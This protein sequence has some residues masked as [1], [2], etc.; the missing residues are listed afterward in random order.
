M[1]K[2]FLLSLQGILAFTL[3]AQIPSGYYATLQGKQTAE[4]KT[5]LHDIIIKDTTRYL[6]YGSGS[7]NRT[8]YGFYNT[9]RDTENS[10][11]LDMYSGV[12]RYFPSNY[13]SSGYPGFGNELHIE[14]SLPKSWWGGY[15][16]AAYKDLNHLY[17][18]DGSTNIS[19][20]DNPLGIVTGN[21]TTNN[22]VSK[23]GPG[24]YPGFAGTV[25]EPAN[26]YKGD[27][28]RSYFYMA[29]A[30]EHYVNVWAVSKPENMMQK[31]KYPVLN[32]GAIELLLDWHR[33]DPVSEKERTRV[34]KVFEIQGN[35]NPFIDYPELVE[36]IWGTLKDKPWG[37]IAGAGDLKLQFSITLS[38]L[39][40]ILNIDTNEKELTCTVF[41]LNGQQMMK[42]KLNGSDSFSLQ[43]LDNGMY[44]IQLQS[45]NKRTTHKFTIN[46]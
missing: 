25:F 42:R 16:W 31:N 39:H 14:H 46:R 12:V 19:K 15:E 11:I 2:L 9:D 10:Q 24:V 32:A 35:R 41:S 4:L 43:M 1:R 13:V 44:F 7:K 30:Y 8:W 38:P 27:F 20:N 3:A 36:Y 18:S 26:E 17:P 28:A 33:K 37:V 5:A 45:G 34:E 21:P 23:I 40:D 6:S 29:T 22:G